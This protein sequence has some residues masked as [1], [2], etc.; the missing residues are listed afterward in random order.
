MR[1]PRLQSAIERGT[2]TRC[3][4]GKEPGPPDVAAV[5]V[6]A[7][8]L[9][10]AMAYLHDKGIIHGDLCGGNVLMTSSKKSEYGWQCKVG[11]STLPFAGTQNMGWLLSKSAS[12]H[13]FAL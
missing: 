12:S 13:E 3:K 6:A 2:F 8:Q 5:L 11:H 4:V 7:E 9:T 1:S 10:R